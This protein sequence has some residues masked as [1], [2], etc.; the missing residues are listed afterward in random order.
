MKGGTRSECT[1]SLASIAWV[2]S[3]NRRAGR[4]EWRLGRFARPAT[5]M[6]SFL[7]INASAQPLTTFGMGCSSF[8]P[9]N[10]RSAPKP[11]LPPPLG[12]FT[13]SVHDR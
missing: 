4:D 7:A 8:V 5:S 1:Y 11:A 2:W 12:Y 3:E 10:A 13:L 6:V 9:N